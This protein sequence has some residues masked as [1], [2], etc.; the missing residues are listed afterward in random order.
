MVGLALWGVRV[1]V[2]PETQYEY[3]VSPASPE[4]VTRLPELA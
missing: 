1:I 4:T 2:F 3:F